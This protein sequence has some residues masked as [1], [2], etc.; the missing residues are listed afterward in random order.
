MATPGDGQDSL[1]QDDAPGG[2]EQR[3][4]MEEQ[5]LF[6][7]ADDAVNKSGILHQE[8]VTRFA[9]ALEERT[10]ASAETPTDFVEPAEGTLDRALAN[11]HHIVFGRRGSGKTSLLTKAR[12][13]LVL[14]RR[15]N[16]FVDMEKYKGHAYPDVLISVL[17]ECFQELRE[18][19]QT[20]AIAPTNRKSFWQ[21][22]FAKP[23]RRPLKKDEAVALSEEA[24]GI[25]D[26][27]YDLLHVTDE[28][29]VEYVY[30]D[31]SSSQ[32]SMEGG[33]AKGPI[34]AK[35]LAARADR[36]SLQE[37]EKL[38]R[39]KTTTLHRNL[40]TY[41]DFLKRVRSLADKDGFLFLDDLYHV[42]RRNQPHVLDYF[43][44]LLK[45][46]GLWLKVGTIKYRTDWYV[47]GDPSIGMK[48]G[49]DTGEIDLDVTLEKYR[50]AKDFLFKLLGELGDAYDVEVG[51]LLTERARD[52]LVLASGG[53]AR[54]FLAILRGAIHI[55]REMGKSTRVGVTASNLASGEHESTKRDEFRKDTLEGADELEKEFARIKTFCLEKNKKNCFLIEKDLT[56]DTY[57]HI[58]QL[59]DLRL[60]HTVASRVKAFHRTDHIYEAYMV[61]VSQYT[62]ERKRRDLDI[63]EFWKPAGRDKMR[64]ASLIYAERD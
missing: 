55:E 33:V 11:W 64:G 50:T 5:R 60:L 14:D 43:H 2:I 26:D 20:G 18:W 15:P 25:I 9:I 30:Q 54:D 57:G 38:Q 16:A 7:V 12:Q 44:R 59:V 10:R 36:T 1:T 29:Q 3:G 19:L 17:I 24:Q 32:R 51:R 31:D 56:T 39:D 45:G 22:W 40:L 6:E 41:Q 21:R 62:G 53:V 37:T 4:G 23:S 42:P 58:K 46:T 48:L 13:Q 28:A 27:L 8:N 63:I 47:H 61:D 49:D 52:R 34:T 35:G